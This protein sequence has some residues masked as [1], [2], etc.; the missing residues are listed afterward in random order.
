MSE[1]ST[2]FCPECHA[3]VGAQDTRCPHCGADFAAWAARP[4]GERLILALQHPLSAARMS[5]IIALGKRGDSAAAAALAACALAHPGDVVQGLEIVRALARMPADAPREAARSALLAHPA[6]AVRSAAQALPG[7][8]TDAAQIARWCH[9]LAEHAEVEPRIAALGS[10]AIPGLRA[11]LAEPPE[12]VNAARLFAVQMLARID[13]PAAHSALRETLYQPPL[14]RLLPVVTE[15]ERAVKS[16]ALTALATHAYAERADDIAWAF[17]VARLPAAARCAGVQRMQTLAPALARALDDDVLGAPAATALL[18]MPDALEDALR[19]PLAG[20]LQRDTA[21]ARLGAVRALLCLAQA[22]QCP[23]P[24]AWQQAWRAAHPALRA[25]AACVAWAQRPR[26][27]LIPALLHGAVLPEADLA[28]ACR[29]ALTVHTAWPL[30]T[31]RVGN[32]LARGV[33]DIYGDR[34]AL[35]RGTLAW[36]GAALI[37]HAAQARPSRLLRM[38]VM[39]LR[40]GLGTDITLTPQQR[41]QLARHPDAELRAALRQRQRSARWWPRRHGY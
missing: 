36:L 13:A 39:L 29:D 17:N 27:A 2:W 32:A 14:D 15:A 10:A 33:P 19:T 35:S 18:A 38:D 1:Q 4:Y 41:A 22:R 8:H 28:Q 21:R 6:H 31:L 5:A 16:A 24:A 9:D 20:W 37:T 26:S 12:V 30:R 7:T 11:L 23:Q 40:A 3:E 34:Q 25:A